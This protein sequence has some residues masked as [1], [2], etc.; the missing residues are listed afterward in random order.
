M[1]H[2]ADPSIS[3]RTLLT[4]FLVFAATGP[5]FARNAD[6]PAKF[7]AALYRV[8]IDVSIF[9][10]RKSQQRFLSRNLRAAIDAMN[11]R[12]APGDAPDMD[13]DPVTDS[14]D[15]DVH[16]LQIKTESQSDTAAAVT[17]NF[18]SHQDK[19]RSVLHYSLVR[20]GGGWKV[21]NIV[22]TGKTPWDVRKI[23]DGP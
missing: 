10:D 8:G 17:V 2:I 7:V 14:N 11:K 9:A 1:M 16:D 15:P 13:F 22:S 23:I 3:R 21:D 18:R 6:D 5:A 4:G 12:T 19:D 20:E